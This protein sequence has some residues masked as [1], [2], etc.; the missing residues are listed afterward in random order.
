MVRKKIGILVL[1]LVAFSGNVK[2]QQ[3]NLDYFLKAAIQSSPLLKEYTNLLGS[4]KIDSSII[5]A[6]YKPR[7][8]A[9]SS[10]TYAPVINGYGY[11]SAITNIGNFS[12]LISI[13]KQMIGKSNLENRYNAI[14]LTNDSVRLAASISE[15]DLRKNVTQQYITAYGSWQQYLYN[16]EVFDL[17]SKEDSML[18]KLTQMSVFRQTDYL[19]FLV[20]L[21]QQH[22]AVT[23]SKIQFET[24]YTQLNLLCGLFDTIIQSVP[25]PELQ[26]N[27]LV[28]PASSVY[29]RKFLVD[30]L[31]L[32]NQHQRIDYDYK[33]KLTLYG[34]AGYVSTLMYL[35]YK[36]FGTSFG[37][38]LE[39]PIYDGGQKKLQHQK[40]NI[41]EQTRRFYRDFFQIEYRQQ[42]GQL[43]QEL[44]S[45]QQLIDET[46]AQ[47]KYVEGLIQANGKLLATGD[48]RMGDYIIAI[49]NYLNARNTITQNTVKKL[50]IIAQINYWN[51]Q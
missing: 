3:K 38:N 23:Q 41:A 49:N 30:S 2:S 51:I 33:P 16:K 35:P 11:E 45:S 48:V 9:N 29:Y 40:V 10:N 5:A 19:T 13:S 14:R 46:T 24:D 20:T 50:Q 43:L 26:L 25:D 37:L 47:L 34:D 28:P 12:E 17:L 36:N 1:L 8:T 32:Q 18:K 44:H 31:L 27:F 39:I 21:Q 15:Q 7:V 4:N 42:V 22:S 6:S